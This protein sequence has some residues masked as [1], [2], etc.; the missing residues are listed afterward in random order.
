VTFMN[1]TATL[2]TG[3]ISAGTATFTTSALAAGPHSITALYGGDP[4]F[5]TSTSSPVT[6]TVKGATT[7]TVTSSVNPSLFGQP[8]TLTATVA[9]VAPATGTPTGTVTFMDG[10]TTL[11]AGALSAG[12]ATFTVSTLTVGS[13]PITAVYSGDTTFSSS[14]S[15]TL[16]Q[17]VNKAG[18][19]TAIAA[20]PNPSTY[21]QLMTMTATVAIVAPGAGT[22]TGT[23]TFRDGTTTLGTAAISGS[24]AVFT[25][26]TLAAGNHFLTAVYGSDVNFNASTS[27]NLNQRVNK[28]NTTTTVTASANPSVFGQSVTFTA[29]L[30]AV[31]PGGGI[32]TGTGTVTFRNGGTTLGSA[33]LSGGTATFTTST[34]AVGTRSIA[35]AYGGDANFN[36]STSANL[37]QVINKANTT[38]SLTS[39]RTGNRV[40]LTAKVAATAP[41]S[42]T[43]GGTVTFRDNGRRLGTAN[44]NA[45]GTA[46]FTTTLSTTGHSITAAYGGN[47]SFNTSTS[48]ALINPLMA[49]GGAVVPAPQTPSLTQAQL[50]PI[51]TQAIALW[52]AAGVKP[53]ALNAMKHTQFVVTDLPGAYLGGE[54]TGRI[55]LD[56]NAAGHG[57]FVDP[58]PGT[59]EEFLPT[60]RHQLGAIDPRAVDRIDLLTVVEHELGHAIGLDDLGSALGDIMSGTL[61]VG[62]RRTIAK[63]DLDAIWARG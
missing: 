4:N 58:T 60:A 9:V 2:G 21:G 43:P 34:L 3:T 29:T 7:T 44:L 8:A 53:Q 13:H 27:A 55:Y 31:A 62:L 49:A 16:P 51:V 39:S 17:T 10:A 48:P 45:A 11:G 12:R 25:T 5:V 56:V 52:A 38:T 30:A 46:I 40:T 37:R 32:A 22:L 35:A 36:T 18:T 1:G 33:A 26:S 59:N 6:Q 14:T 42:G 28:A 47:A 24:T 50:Q 19:A 41:G 23:V 54:E 15:A 20:T 63:A 61:N 57:W